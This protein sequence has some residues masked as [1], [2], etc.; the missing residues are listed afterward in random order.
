ML[1][2]LASDAFIDSLVLLSIA[3]TSSLV[4]SICNLVDSLRAAI[5]LSFSR[6]C[7]SLNSLI[8]LLSFLKALSSNSICLFT[9]R[10]QNPTAVKGK[11]PG[12]ICVMMM[13][14]MTRMMYIH[15]DGKIPGA[16]NFSIS[17]VLS[18]GMAD[19]NSTDDDIDLTF[20]L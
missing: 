6:T 11:I 8:T 10:V 7:N 20:T 9:A 13:M 12:L 3:L 16:I 19:I 1:S 5:F 15:Y 14:T 2:I 17:R 18:V 4:A